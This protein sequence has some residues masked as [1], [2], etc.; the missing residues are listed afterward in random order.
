MRQ[1]ELGLVVR[2]VGSPAGEARAAETLG[3]DFVAAGE[4]VSFHHPTANALMCLAA[5]ATVTERLGLMTAITL[6]PVYP[7]AL[8]AK[9]TAYLD[10]VSGGRLE[11][12]LGIGGE[13]P[14]ELIACGVPPRERG[15]RTSELIAVLRQLWAAQGPSSFEGRF[16]S[17]ENITIDPRPASGDIPIWVSGRSDAAIKRAIAHECGWLPYMYSPRKLAASLSR[18]DELGDHRPQSGVLVWA[19]VHENER[20]ARAMALRSLR[21]NFGQDFHDILTS[22]CLVGSASQ[23][24]ERLHEYG[25][26]GASRIAL[27]LCVEDDHELAAM[28]GALADSVL[29]GLRS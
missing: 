29:P 20:T 7:P 1:M 3:F 26:A 16:S 28:R 2:G 10:S 21:I 22:V 15:P 8:L 13:Y 9:M 12:G 6:A 19:A 11:L 17:Y 24:M 5:S 4:H 23:V 27:A 18:F 14:Q 25:A